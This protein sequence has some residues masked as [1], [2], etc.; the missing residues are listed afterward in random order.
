MTE[1]A[2][3]MAYKEEVGTG[4]YSS[5]MNSEVQL[6]DSSYDE[7]FGDTYLYQRKMGKRDPDVYFGPL[8]C[9]LSVLFKRGFWIVAR[10]SRFQYNNHLSVKVHLTNGIDTYKICKIP[11][12]GLLKMK[13]FTEILSRPIYKALP[14][15]VQYQDNPYKRIDLDVIGKIQDDIEEERK[16]EQWQNNYILLDRAKKIIQDNE[17][18]K[19]SEVVENAKPE[20][21]PVRIP[22]PDPMIGNRLLSERIDDILKG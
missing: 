9:P 2:M 7:D 17:R 18:G 4:S 1:V 16:N 12:R 10:Y 11:V 14:K 3:G 13:D 5:A 8:S 20:P 6:W 21:K 19:I 15:M 22:V